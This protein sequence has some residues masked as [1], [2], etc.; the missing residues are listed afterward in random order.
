MEIHPSSL[1]TPPI[2]LNRFRTDQTSAA[3]NNVD[4]DDLKLSNKPKK[5]SVDAPE[6]VQTTADIE[7]TLAREDLQVVPEPTDVI[8]QFNKPFNKRTQQALTAYTNQ[9]NQPKINQR[10]ELIV[11]IDFFV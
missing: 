9:I 11:G 5:K 4:Q 6:I 8:E 2:G 10:T 1:R 7:K 3:D